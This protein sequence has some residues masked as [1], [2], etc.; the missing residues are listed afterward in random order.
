[1]LGGHLIPG[2]AAFVDSVGRALRRDADRY[3]DIRQRGDNLLRRQDEAD[4]WLAIRDRLR[5]LANQA[6][7]T[8]LKL[9]STVVQEAQSA[10]GQVRA[11]AELPTQEPYRHYHFMRV[12][13]LA[14]AFLRMQ[15]YWQSLQKKKER[16]RKLR[17]PGSNP[18]DGPPS[19]PRAS[20][21][22]SPQ[23]LRAKKLM[24]DYNAAQI[25]DLYLRHAASLYRASPAQGSAAQGGTVNSLHAPVREHAADRQRATSAQQAGDG[26]NRHAG[27]SRPLTDENGPPT[28]FGTRREREETT[29][30][31][32]MPIRTTEPSSGLKPDSSAGTPPVPP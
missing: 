2:A 16:T 14:A 18:T 26:E 12:L 1:M 21:P 29:R 31:G 13:C 9:Q 20:R 17:E 6:E 27:G 15:A 32:P 11:L 5:T 22:Q 7:A 25:K 10:V 4:N 8:H 28:S 23:K 30:S 3:P 19:G 24:A